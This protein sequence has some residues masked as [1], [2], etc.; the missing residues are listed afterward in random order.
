[1][2]KYIKRRDNARIKIYYF[3]TNEPLCF[4]CFLN[5]TFQKKIR[6]SLLRNSG[7]IAVISRS[8]DQGSTLRPDHRRNLVKNRPATTRVRSI[9]QKVPVPGSGVR[10]AVNCSSDKSTTK[11]LRGELLTRSLAIFIH[12]PLS[13]WS[14]HSQAG[15]RPLDE[16]TRRENR[17]SSLDRKRWR[18]WLGS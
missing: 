16:T 5:F 8:C 6:S 14:W 18:R 13:H 4:R 17:H 15:A 12:F 7:R 9:R 3:T 11:F 1:M 10:W 2:S